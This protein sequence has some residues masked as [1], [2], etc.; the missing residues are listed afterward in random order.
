MFVLFV[1][2]PNVS[3]STSELRVRLALG[4]WSKSSSKIFLLTV[5]RR[6]FFCSSHVFFVS[7]VS[8]AFASVHCCLVVIC[9]EG[10]DLLALVGDLYCIFCFFPLWYPGS[11]MVFDCIVSGSLPSFLLSLHLRAICFILQN[12]S[13]FPGLV[14]TVFSNHSLRIFNS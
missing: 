1:I 11:G 7:C 5:P 6:Y 13:L 10:A 9:W 4:H 3:W 14:T 2:V 8:H 12:I